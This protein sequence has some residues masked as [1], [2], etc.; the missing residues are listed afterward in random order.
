MLEQVEHLSKAGFALHW[1]HPR[2]KRPIGEDWAAK[3]VA[4][5]KSLAA[6][7]QKGRN[8]GVRPGKWSNLGG[9]YLHII[10]VDVRKDEFAPQAIAKLREMLPEFDFDRAPAVISGS[11]GAS[12]HFYLLTDKP[13]PP[14][15]F[16]HSPS[17]QMVWSADKGRDVKKWDWE[18]HLL[19]TGSNAVIPP[20]IHPETGKAYAWLR[21][22][23]QFDLEVGTLKSVPSAAVERLI[24]FED[25]GEIDPARLKPMGLTLAEM[26]AYLTDLPFE[27]WLEDREGWYRTGMAIHHETSGSTEGFNLWCEF[28][29]KS[30]KFSLKDSQAVWKSFKG[31]GERPFRFASLAAVVRDERLEQD[32]EDYGDEEDDLGTTTAGDDPFDDILGGSPKKVK[33]KEPSKSQVRLA[34][35]KVEVT[36]GKDTPGWVNRLN[37]KHAV[38]RVSGKTVVMDFLHDGRVVYG[39]VNDLHNF[40][41]ND[42]RPKDDTTVPVTKLWMQHSQRRSYPNGIVFLPNQEIEGAYNHWQGWSVDADATKSC[43]LILKHLR[44]VICNDDDAHFNYQIGWLAHLVQKPEE[45]PGVAVVYVGRKGNGKDTVFEYVGRMFEHHYITVASQEQMVGKFNQHQEKCLLLHM[46]EG[47]WAGNKQAEGMLKYLITSTSVMIEPKGMNAFPIKSVL[48]LFISSNEKW[49]VPATAD[50]R[51][52]FA[53]KVSER[54]RNDHAYFEALRAEMMGDGPAGLLHFLKNLDISRFQVRAVPDTQALGEQKLQGLKNV[55]RWWHEVLQEGFIEGTQRNQTEVEFT[56]SFWLRNRIQIE[57]TE[58]RDNYARWMRTRRYDGEEVGEVEF[59]KRL[60]D[61]MPSLA[62]TRPNSKGTRVRMFSIVPLQDARTEFETAIG[63]VVDWPED[64][65]AETVDEDDLG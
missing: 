55:E 6:S 42:R 20:S 38:A 1:L 17:F 33:A 56:N 45:K 12:R 49:V 53:L 27:A 13:F 22:F 32:F 60:T 16:A 3:P 5:P 35:E 46:Q 9:V 54:R 62:T 36:L 48:R 7:Y 29:K 24:G 50:E 43:Q 34:K 26:R 61:L 28:S 63:S 25:A 30:E 4:T 23:D 40:Y 37:K 41:E 15:K 52:F 31:R 57:K 39:S 8:I 64:Q 51:R 11:G 47:F 59:T 44:E 14:R 21:E 2:S 58:L 10:D 18:L 19:G 65:V